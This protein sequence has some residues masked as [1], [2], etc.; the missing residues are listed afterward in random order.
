MS[1]PIR[2]MAGRHHSRRDIERKFFEPSVTKKLDQYKSPYT[3]FTEIIR[4]VQNKIQKEGLTVSEAYERIRERY[5]MQ[6]AFNGMDRFELFL[7]RQVKDGE[8]LLQA[9]ETYL[10]VR[11]MGAEIAEQER[12]L[13]T[14]LQGRFELLSDFGVI[15]KLK[16]GCGHEFY[17]HP[18]ALFMGLGCP[19]CDEKLSPE[20]LANRILSRLGAGK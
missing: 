20:E 18:Y 14:E 2:T 10:T 13:R 4:S 5:G 16:C 8:C 6:C 17:T 9:A 3:D 12:A 1:V 15:I 19:T 7:Q 11:E